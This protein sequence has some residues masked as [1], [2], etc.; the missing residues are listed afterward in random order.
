MNTYAALCHRLAAVYDEGE[1]RAVVRLLLQ[2]QF[3]LSWADVL[4]GKVSEL[5][6]DDRM[7]LEE[8]ARRLEQGEPVQYILGRE[9]FC[10][11]SFAV[12]PGVLIP[13]PET[14]ELCEW[15][16]EEQGTRGEGQGNRPAPSPSL[17]DIGTG[18]GC[19]SITLALA[20]P[21]ARVTA[22]DISEAALRVAEGNARTL[23]ARVDF[24][25]QD[26]LHPPT[27]TARWQAIVSNPP[28]VCEQERSAMAPHVL[29]HEPEQ[30]LFVPDDDPL[31]F[32]RAIARYAA[33]ALQSGGRLY[34][35][36][37]PTQADALRNMLQ[38]EGF[39]DIL[40]RHDQF[41]RLRMARATKTSQP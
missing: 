36:F 6:A 8:M 22:W 18:S 21:S 12:G 13:R 29:R 38:G 24:A 32:Y 27:D 33:Q 31:L 39:C 4:C 16:V 41:G 28:Y 17:L 15:V 23:G 37:N 35:E 30:A 9:M 1:A 25:R 19:I 20:M 14:E 5:S 2:E 40:L 11:R 26:A 3:H 7:L 10:G 34:F